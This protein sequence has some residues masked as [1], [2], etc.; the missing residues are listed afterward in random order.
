M[1]AAMDFESVDVDV[2]LEN[3]NARLRPDNGQ[4]I[5]DVSGA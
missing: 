3:D 2:A 1:P 4:T 5:D